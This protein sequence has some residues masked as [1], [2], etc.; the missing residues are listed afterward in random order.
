MRL[1]F[2]GKN[3]D[4]TEQTEE[5]E[6]P[7]FWKRLQFKELRHS[8][9]NVGFYEEEKKTCWSRLITMCNMCATCVQHV[10]NK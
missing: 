8:K 2:V 5:M 6:L 9:N 3:G 1:F 4:V 7:P 10:C